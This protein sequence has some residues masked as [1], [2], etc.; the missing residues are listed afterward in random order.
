MPIVDKADVIY[1]TNEIDQRLNYLI[2]N[3]IK[4]ILNHRTQHL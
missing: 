2:L 4:C 1:K 3:N